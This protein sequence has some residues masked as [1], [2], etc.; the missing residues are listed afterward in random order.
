M[1]VNSGCQGI[2]ARAWRRSISLGI[3]SVWLEEGRALVRAEKFCP[4]LNVSAC[5]SVVATI[6]PPVTLVIV[7]MASSESSHSEPLSLKDVE[8]TGAAYMTKPTA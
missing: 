5:E 7:T 3:H 2:P 6:T 1:N 4:M 8:P